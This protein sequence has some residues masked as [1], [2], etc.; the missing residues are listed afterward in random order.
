MEA[1][2][3]NTALVD[4]EKIGLAQRVILFKIDQLNFLPKF[5]LYWS[6]SNPFQSLLLSNATGSTALGLKAS[7]IG[8]LKA[9][10]CPIQ[11]QQSIVNYL[12]KKTELIDKKIIK[13]ENRIQKLKEYRQSL[14]SEVVTGK[15]KVVN[16]EAY[17]SA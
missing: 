4:I 5:I 14:I 10:T 7:K 9:L 2:L 13:E 3:G 1:P 17:E 11:E 15:K 12:D 6:R 8:Y 16:A